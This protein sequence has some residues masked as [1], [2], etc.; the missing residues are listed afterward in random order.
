MRVPVQH[1]DQRPRPAPAGTRCPAPSPARH[2]A[3]GRACTARNSRSGL[4]TQTTSARKA[5]LAEP[6][7]G[8]QRLGH[9][10]A[11][12]RQRD[13]RLGD[14][15]QRVRPGD[16]LA[17]P[18][19]PRGRVGRHRGQR[20]VHRPGRQPQV[21]RGPARPA[22]LAER[23]EQAP[24]GVQREG[25]LP[26]RAARLLEPDR[27]RVDRLVCAA[28][29]R[30]RHPGRRADQDRL[31]AGVDAERPG[32][33]RPLHE[34]VVEHADRQQRLAPPA[35]GRPELA[36]AA[37]P[38]W[39]RRCR[40][41]R[42]GR[43]P[44]PASAGSS[45]GRRRTSPAGRRATRRPTL[46]TQ[47]PRLVDELTSGLTVTTRAPTS[48]AARL[49]SS[50][51]RPSAAWVVA[52]PCGVRPRSAGTAGLSTVDTG[53]RRSRPAAAA[54]RPAGALSAGKPGPRVGRV[55][56]EPVGQRGQLAGG[57]QRG[58]VLRVPLDGQPV[59]LERVRD[60]HRRPAC[61]R[62]PA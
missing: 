38:G 28:L 6:V 56:P 58:M 44:S 51:V 39:S 48:G 41:R 1:G 36:D 61:R 57:Q 21:R 8:G 42:A 30:E 34:R 31:P 55:E 15:A 43:S 27:R 24:L 11:H 54:S 9:Q 18:P 17:P 13:R 16:H 4:V 5:E 2:R 14:P 46:F 20:L 29:R 7:G 50:R 62:W 49:R 45:P 12:H 40:A 35:P 53:G 37:R 32:L 22:E 23:G 26:A 25:R 3:R 10:R 59:P 19:F 33:Q 52:L 60:D 47:P